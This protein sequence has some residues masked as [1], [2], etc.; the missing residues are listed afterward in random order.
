MG[1]L[2]ISTG[3]AQSILHGNN[4][5]GTHVGACPGLL[6]ESQTNPSLSFKYTAP[7]MPYLET[8]TKLSR[9]TVNNF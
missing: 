9:V 7:L 3:I 8:E 4:L 5:P 6:D 2:W 1:V